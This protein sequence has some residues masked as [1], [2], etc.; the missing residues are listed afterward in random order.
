MK[1]EEMSQ[2]KDVLS[3][4][5]IKNLVA[6]LGKCTPGD[7]PSEVFEA[8]ARI[9]VYPAVEWVILRN[10]NKKL[11]VLLTKREDDDPVWPSLLHIPGTVLRPTDDS[12]S[13]AF[14]RL[15]NDELKGLH[16]SGPTLSS[17]SFNTYARGQ[18]I[19]IEYWLI[20]EDS[21]N[22]NIGKFYNVEYLPK[23]LIKEQVIIIKRAVESYNKES[24]NFEQ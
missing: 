5:D 13:D 8:V 21:K 15:Y 6:L 7:L 4:T 23:N 18:S 22:K 19:G 17:V 16:L 12:F 24:L 20:C 1:Q 9:A 14:E 11:E 2:N 10:K 3:E